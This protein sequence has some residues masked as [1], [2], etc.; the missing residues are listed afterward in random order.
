LSDEA[1]NDNK[2]RK[3]LLLLEKKLARSE[4][5]RAT[6]EDIKDKNQRLLMVINKQLDEQAAALSAKN[7]ELAE[8][9]EE[10]ALTQSSLVL[11]EK[12][13]SLGRLVAGIAHELN[14][15]AGAVKSGADVV[16][17][18][19]QRMGRIIDETEQL[20][21]HDKLRRLFQ[22]LQSSSSGMQQGCDRVTSIVNSLQTFAR[23]DE[24]D[25]KQVD[26]TESIESVLVLL[27][28]ELG[29]SIEIETSFGPRTEIYCYP[30]ELNQV[31]LNLISNAVQAIDG[32]GR[33]NVRTYDDESMLH[34][35]VTDDGRGISP[36]RLV[37]IFDPA[38]KQ[39]DNRVAVGFGLSTCYRIAQKHGGTITVQS[40][41]GRGSVFT[42]SVSKELELPPS[43]RVPLPENL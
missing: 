38:F 16:D 30:Q 39:R 2:L 32:A 17:L 22:M 29:D 36:D 33:V 21:E 15:P 7:D 18:C 28:H 37:D 24:A 35:E 41:L 6:L 11:H 27:N 4:R 26:V 14:T 19:V 43:I 12:M 40:E 13:A 3:R 5:S 9:L 8:T 42:L 25:I 31:L 1:A 23:L 20:A 34:V 10:L